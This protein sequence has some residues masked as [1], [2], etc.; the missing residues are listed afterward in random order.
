ML[1]TISEE[2]RKNTREE[3][4]VYLFFAFLKIYVIRV[5]ILFLILIMNC[6]C[7]LS[8]TIQVRERRC[9]TSEKNIS[10]FQNAQYIFC[11]MLKLVQLWLVVVDISQN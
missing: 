5:L 10:M 9:G 2:Q 11:A 6:H 7:F 1:L 8:L 4:S 3:E